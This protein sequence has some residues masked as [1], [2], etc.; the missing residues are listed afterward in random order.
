MA[1][2][3][4]VSGVFSYYLEAKSASTF[5]AFRDLIPRSAI[6]TR[7]S[8]HVVCPATDV[9]VGDLIHLKAGDRVPADVRLI[10]AHDFLC[11]N[12]LQT[13]SDEP[14]GRTNECSHSNPFESENLVFFSTDCVHGKFFNL[15]KMSLN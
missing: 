15:F 11:V 9:V 13:G 5:L 10:E 3:V 14:F 4:F 12:P 7:G 1:G 6:V 2:V 8:C